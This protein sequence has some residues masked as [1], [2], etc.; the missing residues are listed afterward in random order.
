MVEAYQSAIFKVIYLGEIDEN[1]QQQDLIINKGSRSFPP[2][3]DMDER[4]STVEYFQANR[5][6]VIPLEGVLK[7]HCGDKGDFITHGPS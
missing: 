7:I 2:C 3:H 5:V 4:K 6:N 1:F